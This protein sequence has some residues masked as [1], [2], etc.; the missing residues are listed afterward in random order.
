MTPRSKHQIHSLVFDLSI[1]AE[2]MAAGL[3]DR[4]SSFSVEAAPGILEEVLDKYDPP[5]TVTRIKRIE[6]DLGI[7]KTDSLETD[8]GKKL[9][10]KLETS[11]FEKIRGPIS[12]PQEVEFVPEVSILIDQLEYFFL[13][14]QLPWHADVDVFQD[15]HRLVIDMIKNSP[16]AL[17]SL[18]Q[19]IIPLKSARHRLIFNL[20]VETLGILTETY[21]DTPGETRENIQ[22]L[23]LWTYDRLQQAGLRV[24]K[25]L[26]RFET[27]II[28]L[29]ESPE[30]RA[31]ALL[32]KWLE[33]ELHPGIFPSAEQW[34]AFKDS[35][36]LPG[37]PLP[38]DFPQKAAYLWEILARKLDTIEKPFRQP[39]QEADGLLTQTGWE[40]PKTDIPI[41]GAGSEP[42]KEAIR[43][44]ESV[45][46][47]DS[48]FIRNSG[49]VILWPYLESYLKILKLVETDRFIS[50][51]HQLQAVHELEFLARG[52]GEYREYDLVLNKVLCGFPLTAPVD[53]GLKAEPID[54]AEAGKL[55]PAVIRNWKIIADT[56]VKG[57]RNSFLMRDGRLTPQEN[58]WTLIID[59]K[60][61][62]VLLEK[63]PYSIHVVKLPWMEK[64]IYVEW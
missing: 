27:F 6:V 17:R 53:T 38:D 11:V 31:P 21:L 43:E 5:G 61:Y 16:E 51:R 63:L 40:S 9:L 2:N 8:I 20:E 24:H 50:S 15:I 19:R 7:V 52:R 36:L 42:G 10:E 49:L 47:N 30:L 12:R 44:K 34:N 45:T 14:G 23:I 26:F 33:Q 37:K 60:G 62:D 1:P 57:F 64:P 35:I 41:A 39:R 32:E 48:L 55:L 59:R 29:L 46:S 22:T 54:P 28:Q 3:Q 18:L 58:N 56:S 4:L 25:K 13:T